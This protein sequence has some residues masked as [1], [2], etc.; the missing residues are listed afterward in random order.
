[1]MHLTKIRVPDPSLMFPLNYSG[2]HRHERHEHRIGT[3]MPDRTEGSLDS[4]P[5]STG[6]CVISSVLQ[7]WLKLLARFRH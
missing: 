1:M 5:R 2:L 7:I 3:L 6:H 4:H